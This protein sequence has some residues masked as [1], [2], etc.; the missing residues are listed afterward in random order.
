MLQ[1]I[2]RLQQEVTDLRGQL[3]VNQYELEK[4]KERQHK[5]YTD[6]DE[7][8]TRMDKPSAETTATAEST[9]PLEV[10][11]PVENVTAA[12]TE[13]DT[14][15]TLETVTPDTPETDATVAGMEESAEDEEMIPPMEEQPGSDTAQTQQPESPL[16]AQSQYQAAFGLLRNAD[17][18]QA[19]V[20][21]NKFLAKY[22]DSKYSDNA[23]YW[24][25]EAYYVTRRFNDAITEYMKLISNYPESQKVPNGLLKIGYSYYE[26]GQKEE[27]KRI[28]QD[29]IERY[30]ESSAASDAAKRLQQGSAS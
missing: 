22:P 18:D 11:T 8:L 30:P 7:R 1:Q 3:E 10:I 20:E 6:L 26:L 16:V 24:M 25:G 28:L 17:Y 27:G 14:T 23:Q 2:Q 29:L 15:L 19:I 13:A 9:P 21:F 12:G 5:L 4:L